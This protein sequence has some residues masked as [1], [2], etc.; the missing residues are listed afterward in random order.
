[1]TEVIRAQ[2]CSACP[3]RRDVPSGVWEPHEYDKLPPY[4][5]DTFAQPFAAFACHAS[6]HALCHGWAVCH[7]QRGHRY[8][9]VALRI[10][11]I[12]ADDVPAASVPLFTSGFEARE[13]GQRDTLRPSPEAVEVVERLTRKHPRLRD[14]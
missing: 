13:H 14:G 7:S 9:L 10:L 4:D 8:E 1:M 3:Y 2:A 5:A 6:P 11:G 12:S